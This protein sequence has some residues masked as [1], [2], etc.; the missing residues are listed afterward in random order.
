MQVLASDTCIYLFWRLVFYIYK[1]VHIKYFKIR[2]K[3]TFIRK[4]KKRIKAKKSLSARFKE[5][6]FS[7]FFLIIIN[8]NFQEKKVVKKIRERFIWCCLIGDSD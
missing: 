7:I 4:C 1:S 5:P 8:Y 6:I 2:V 3:Y